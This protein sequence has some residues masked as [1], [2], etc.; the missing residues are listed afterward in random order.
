MNVVAA[1][2]DACRNNPLAQGGLAARGLTRT[3]GATATT[4]MMPSTSIPPSS[5]ATR[6]R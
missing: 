6:D 2:V 1:E 4:P 3:Q 5:P